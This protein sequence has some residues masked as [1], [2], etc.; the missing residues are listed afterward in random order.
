M[1]TD[2]MAVL[3]M[4]EIKR[5]NQE[6][7]ERYNLISSGVHIQSPLNLRIKDNVNLE[8][9]SLNQSNDTNPKI[10]KNMFKEKLRLQLINRY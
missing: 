6:K 5:K 10:V 2:R 4:K 7:L 9:L 8:N 1:G 3:L